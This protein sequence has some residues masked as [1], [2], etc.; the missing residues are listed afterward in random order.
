MIMIKKKYIRFFVLLCVMFLCVLMPCSAD[1]ATTKWKNTCKAYAKFLANNES[2]YVINYDVTS[3][4]P[5][6]N[7]TIYCFMLVDIDKNGIPEMIGIHYENAKYALITVYT[8]K[9]GKVK[10]IKTFDAISTAQGRYDSFIC[11]Q[12]HFHLDYNGGFVGY[13]HC[14]YKLKSG[15]FSLYAQ[16]NYEA[17][18]NRMTIK[19]NGKKASTKAY[20]S[21]VKKCTRDKK[22]LYYRNQANN[23][24]KYLYSTGITAVSNISLSNIKVAMTKGNTFTLNVTVSPSDATNKAL[25]WS[26]SDTSV[27]I[28]SAGKVTALKVGTAFITAKSNNGKTATCKV[29]ISNPSITPSVS[30]SSINCS[31]SSTGKLYAT[32][33]P[34]NATVSWSSSNSNI[35][36]VDSYGNISAKG[37]GS[38]TITAKITYDGKSYSANKVITV[39]SRTNYGEWSGWSPDV[40][41]SSS[42]REVETT[43]LYRYYCFYCPVCGGREPFQGAS[44]CHKYTLNSADGRIVWSTIPYNCSNPKSYS[45]TST[46]YYTESLGDGLRWNFSA[47]NLNHTVQGT[48]DA[49]GPAT[50]VIVKGYR[51]RSKSYSYYFN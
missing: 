44:D 19:V 8:Y 3:H 41:S 35:V 32:T 21:A 1:A 7:N 28:V 16:K 20:N 17:L 29:T 14:G 22:Y 24:K 40:I 42:S 45:Y 43:T 30:I 38:T 27:A 49:A 4:N 2:N 47:G 5:E 50:P 11:K 9:N 36:S 23:R 13:N 37:S 10:K 34:N 39:Y 31:G 6:D 12:R 33:V 51:S 46:K 15:K 48:I 18:P 25:T 26:S